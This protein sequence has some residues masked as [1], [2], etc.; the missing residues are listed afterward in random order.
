LPARGGPGGFGLPDHDSTFPAALRLALKLP[1]VNTT[2]T[3]DL[4]WTGR[5]RSIAA[6]LLRSPQH[7]ALV[8]PGPA[9]T[10]PVLREHLSQHGLA[11]SDINSILLTHIHLDHAAATGSLVRENPRIAVYLHTRGMAHMIDPARLLQSASRLYGD[12]LEKLFGD[13]LPV[14]ASNLHPLQG[15]ETLQLG[16]R[17]LRVLYTPGHA[18]HHVTYFDPAE[19][20]AFVGDTAGVSIN[21][22][23]FVL[24]VTPPPDIS[25]ELWD[26]SL[27][28]IAALHPKKLFLTHFSFA[29]DPEAHIS[30]YRE[31]LHRWS[32][33]SAEI[34]SAR[35]D[36]PSAMRRFANG[37]AA[38]VAQFLSPEDASHYLFNAGLDLSWLG[39]ARYHRKRAEAAA[40]PCR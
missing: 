31:R 20:I 7:V 9:S 23:R 16:L 30:S 2:R 13:F 29:E 10:I 28:A 8:D 12:N 17:T 36:D 4:R 15:A 27:Q 34:I 26:A 37:V 38:E 40:K 39:L 11:V 19:E 25:I 32:D 18:S 33:L 5:S 14:P 3:L 21:G 22:H 1:S 24:P 6:A 35:L